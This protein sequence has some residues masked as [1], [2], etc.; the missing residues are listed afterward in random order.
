MILSA[1]KKIKRRLE[2]GG[3]DEIGDEEA[4]GKGYEK[5]TA[6]KTYKK[7]SLSHSEIV[8]VVIQA[9]V[10]S[11]GY[12]SQ[13]DLSLSRSP[14]KCY[15]KL[16]IYFRRIFPATLRLS[17]SV[18]IGLFKRQDMKPLVKAILYTKIYFKQKSELNI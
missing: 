15:E 3:D 14:S 12:F 8:F 5:L 9:G 18:I 1:N 2:S 6:R 10:L 11:R 4:S 7:S 13:A 16:C 17:R